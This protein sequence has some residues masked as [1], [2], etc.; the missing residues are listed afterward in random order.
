MCKVEL[1]ANK[2]SKKDLDEI[3]SSINS[4]IDT[5]NDKSDICRSIIEKYIRDIIINKKDG[6]SYPMQK[7]YLDID[8]KKEEHVDVCTF[9]GITLDILIGLIYLLKKHRKSCS[10]LTTNF[11]ENKDLC[12][13]YKQL[14]IIVGTRC[15][16]MNFEL[17]WVYYKLYLSDKFYERFD[18]C[19]KHKNTRFIIIP[20][21]IEL[22]LGSHSNYLIYD[23]KTKELERFEPY[24][25]DKP[26]QFDYNPTLLDS[27]LKNRLESKIEGLKYISPK[28]Y[29][30]KIGLQVF[31]S[32]ETIC[33]RI[34]DPK[35]FC[36]LW[37][38]WYTDMRLKYPDLERDILVKELI[39]SIKA[40][41]ISFKNMIRNYSK[42]ISDLR[43]NL[44]N[45]AKININDWINDQYTEKQ[46]NTLLCKL[47]DIIKSII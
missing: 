31:D 16:F 36:A 21:G 34:G 47:T 37:A 32:S 42:N 30:P 18:K 22:R 24:G 29:L 28:D 15:E 25:S 39:K 10:T 41:N 38:I 1:F 5:K 12:K 14:G 35:G 19:L 4:N 46:L 2:I 6:Y 9:T 43:N 20:L 11:V 27:V 44:L 26:F 8:I 13:Y 33:R 17:V 40:K 3:F 45:Q 7:R 23:T